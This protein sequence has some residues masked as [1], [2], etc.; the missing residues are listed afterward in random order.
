LGKGNDRGA[1]SSDCGSGIRALF[2]RDGG[3][4]EEFKEKNPILFFNSGDYIGFRDNYSAILLHTK[5]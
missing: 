5:G 2:M 3:F 1:W 4:K